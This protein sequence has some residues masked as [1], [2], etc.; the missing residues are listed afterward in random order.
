MTAI[1][2]RPAW[3]VV[4]T[5]T[6]CPC[7]LDAQ[8]LIP[9]R[10]D[11]SGTV[12]WFAHDRDVREGQ[13]YDDD[14]QH[15]WVFAGDV[16]WYWTE[17]LKSEIGISATTTGSSF[18]LVP[19]AAPAL[20][21]YPYAG[22][23]RRS[24][25]SRILAQQIYQFG[26]NAWV[27]PYVGAGVAVLWETSRVEF[28]TPPFAPPGLPLPPPA[29]ADTATRVKPVVSAGFKAYISPRAFFRGDILISPWTTSRDV[30]VRGGIGV[31]LK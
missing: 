26:H 23:R 13:V 16:G 4:A 3:A 8:T 7:S 19:I 14:T 31:D 27:H 30:T 5:M 1:L 15:R 11:T 18:V 29:P 21:D 20:R 10:L 25:E 24:R 2:S 22:G 12:G 6:V 9:P 17:H 28:D